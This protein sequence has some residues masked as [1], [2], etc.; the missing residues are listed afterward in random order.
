MFKIFDT[1]TNVLNLF[2]FSRTD[3]SITKKTTN[4]T[5]Q[6]GTKILVRNVP[7]QATEKEIEEL[8]K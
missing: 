1:K 4:I 5:E 7:F 6:T 2:H 8:F 3:V